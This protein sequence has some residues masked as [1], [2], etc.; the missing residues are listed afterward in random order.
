MNLENC[1][2]L[3]AGPFGFVGIKKASTCPELISKFRLVEGNFRSFEEIG[4]Y[5][6]PIGF[7]STNSIDGMINAANAAGVYC[8]EYRLKTKKGE[9][10]KRGTSRRPQRMKASRKSEKKKKKKRAA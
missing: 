3:T 2:I 4:G 10:Q 7:F 9:Q 6:E 8:H 5:G 1:L